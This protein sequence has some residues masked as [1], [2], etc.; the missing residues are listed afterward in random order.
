MAVWTLSEKLEW[1]STRRNIHPLT[2][3]MVIN[4]PLSVSFIYYDLWHPPCS[5]H[6]P[7]SLFPQSLQVFFGLSLD[8]A[9]STS[10]CIHFFTQ[11][12]SSF[13]STCPY[14]GNL[15]CCTTEIMSSNPLS[16]PHFSELYFVAWCH[17][18]IWPFSFLPP[19]FPFFTGHISLPCSILLHTQLLYNLPLKEQSENVLY[20]DRMLYLSNV[21]WAY[22]C[23]VYVHCTGF[24]KNS[25]LW[26][27]I[28]NFIEDRG[29]AKI[30]STLACYNF[31]IHEWISR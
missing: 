25:Q 12:L 6:V 26:L 23:Y 9:P 16:Q 31:D 10:C 7:D 19:H 15:F 3:I 1:A 17:T 22:Q 18:S 28:Y 14:I 21:L 24:A 29:C 11:S 27:A 30:R 4:H 2:P 20:I 13:H 5:I 8:M